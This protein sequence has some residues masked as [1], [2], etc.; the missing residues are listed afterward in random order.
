M[1]EALTDLFVSNT[2]KRGYTEQNQYYE[3]VL[4][5]IGGLKQAMTSESLRKP[6]IQ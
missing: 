4:E 3:Q 2:L 5:Q 1:K 6:N